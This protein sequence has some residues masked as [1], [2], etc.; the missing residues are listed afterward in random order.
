MNKKIIFTSIFFLLSFAVL[1]SSYNESKSD[2]IDDAS[3]LIPTIV[4]TKHNET[5]NNSENKQI[6]AQIKP[7]KI[8]NNI[9]ENEPNADEYSDLKERNEK[10]MI[11]NIRR[12]D[13]NNIN[14]LKMA[15]NNI[16]PA[17]RSAA[18]DRY[19]ELEGEYELEE[20]VI[21]N[22][23]QSGKFIPDVLTHLENETDS[24]V[25]QKAFDYIGEYAGKHDENVSKTISNLLQRD[26][27]TVGILNR[28]GEL[29]MDNYDMSLEQVK[30]SI[31][32]SPSYN[33]LQE[34]E[35]QYISKTL[36]SLSDQYIT[37][38]P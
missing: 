8:T 14:Q 34:I 7:V 13:L 9:I 31:Q 21:R 5:A 22:H 18:I 3:V 25:Q 37:R 4:D 36:R 2:L 35:I 32:N 10:I 30:S 15:L 33:R 20:N 23:K 28:I 17:I 26:D 27:L 12:I 1:F 16:N 11:L 24:F 19:R 38:N 29:G 6:K